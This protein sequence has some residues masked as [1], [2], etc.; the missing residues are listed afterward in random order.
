V[1][2]DVERL[3]GKTLTLGEQKATVCFNSGVTETVRGVLYLPVLQLLAFY[4]SLAFGLDADHPRNL[5][6]VVKLSKI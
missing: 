4:R 1:L 5:N 6:A 2:D 3:G